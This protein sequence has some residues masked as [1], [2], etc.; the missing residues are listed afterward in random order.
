MMLYHQREQLKMCRASELLH[1][2]LHAPTSSKA[3]MC[4][5]LGEPQSLW[6]SF[7]RHPKAQSNFKTMNATYLPSCNLES[8]P[9]HGSLELPRTTHVLWPW[10]LDLR[11]HALRGQQEARLQIQI[12][13]TSFQ[14]TIS[15]R[16]RI[17]LCFFFFV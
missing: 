4:P 2:R 12:Q 1:A 13:S 14:T 3:W 17:F 15:F 9:T 5:K 7:Q 16:V 8:V 6:L 10:F 11:K